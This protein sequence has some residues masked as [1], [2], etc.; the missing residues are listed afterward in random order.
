[1][2]GKGSV[3]V[4]QTDSGSMSG[5]RCLADIEPGRMT[6]LT[7]TGRSEGPELLKYYGSSARSGPHE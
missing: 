3:A 7:D 5:L 4:V 1:M 6:A 2:T